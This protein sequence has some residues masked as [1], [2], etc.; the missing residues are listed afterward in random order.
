MRQIAIITF[1]LSFIN[2]NAQNLIW[3]SQESKMP[4]GNK[5]WVLEDPKGKLSIQD[6]QTDSI[7][8]KFKKSEKVILNFGFTES[9]HWLKFNLENNTNDNLVLEIAH[10]FLPTTDLYYQNDS[11]TITQIKAGYNVSLEEKQIKNH[12]QVFLLPKGKKEYFVKLLSHSHPLPI[13]VWNKTVFELKSQRQKISYG[14]YLGFM[15]FVILSSLFFYFTLRNKLHIIYALTVFIYICYAAAVM[16]GFVLY[17]FPKVDMMFW[18]ITIPAIGIPLQLTY[19]LLFLEVKKY[20]PKLYKF[21]VGL[22]LVFVSYIFIKLMLPLTTVLAINTIAALISFFVMG[23]IG[24]KVGK[25]G[26]KFGYYFALAYFIYFILVLTEAT[27]IQ[28]GKPTYFLELSHVA[29]AT[30]I[31]AFILSY[32]LSKRFEWEKKELEKSKEEANQKLLESTIENERIVKEQNIILE[33]KV[34]QRTE[35]LQM[36]NAELNETLITVENE[37]QKSDKLLLN[38]L[39]E[40]TAKEL[41]E[42]G[43]A[44]PKTHESVTVLFTDFKNF[45]NLSENITPEQLVNDLNKCFSEFDKII[46]RNNLEKIKTIGDAFMAVGGL[47]TANNTHEIDA[48]RAAIEIRN[49]INE[50]RDKQ[51]KAGKIAWE[52]R[53]GIHTGKVVSGVVGLHKFSY[54]IWGDTVNTAARMETSSEAGKINVSTTTYQKIKHLFKCQH[55]GKIEAKG[56]G[57]IDM[58][59]VEGEMLQSH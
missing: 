36:A 21:T 54:D 40:T 24:V 39:P 37:R 53:I 46:Q 22:I 9:Y 30:L 49:F 59:F 33:K 15:F 32:L 19:C 31:E 11:G 10:A 18:Y 47:P 16:D 5:L 44:T 34:N 56:K 35:Q 12:F 27:Y 25:K 23:Y 17:F 8:N 41:K 58:Y 43:F 6:I 20:L 4:I 42:N 28:T 57:D 50:W 38:I 14:V 2:L 45:T 3:N 1:F 26:N 7:K 51:T 48:V 52:L 29:M 13:T 55:R